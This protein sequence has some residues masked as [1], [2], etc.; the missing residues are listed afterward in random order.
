MK[1]RPLYLY[2]IT[3]ILITTDLDYLNFSDVFYIS[4]EEERAASDSWLEYCLTFQNGKIRFIVLN[5][6][7]VQDALKINIY[8][9]LKS[10]HG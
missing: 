5:E 2:S 6:S 3:Q 9:T 4:G 1:I 8:E 10:L 7:I